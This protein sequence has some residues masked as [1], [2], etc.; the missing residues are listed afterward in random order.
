MFEFITMK[1]PHLSLGF[2]NRIR[3][4]YQKHITSKFDFVADYCKSNQVRNV[5]FTGDV[6]DSSTE[7]KWS[8]KKYR[9]NKRF[10]ETFIDKSDTMLYSNV[11]NHDMFHGFENS[12]DTIF[13]EMVHDGIINNITEV[14]IRISDENNYVKV[15]GIDYSNE[16]NIVL[17]AIRLFDEET[18]PGTN[19]FKIAILHS[20]VTPNE[21][22]YVTD[23]T[24]ATLVKDFPDIDMFI[25]GHYHVGYDTIVM[26]RE[27]GK[28]CHLIN[29][30]NFTRVVRDYETELDEHTPEFEHVLITYD[31]IL[32][33]FIVSTKTVQVPM[34]PYNDAFVAKAID[35]LKKSKAEIF[36]F[37]DNFDIADIKNATSTDDDMITKIKEKNDYTDAAYIKAVEYLND[38][39]K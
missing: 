21:V 28:D 22:D 25:F 10:L 15:Q 5:L 23:F 1:D 7:D 35:L 14:P 13:G 12:N 20:N 8:F 39:K 3:T 18:Y 38:A 36:N 29:N 37:F 11:G 2:Q 16:S 24:Y 27:G 30:W 33:T 17:D 26:Q 6:F 19:M 34:V 4:D 9:K 32:G 31:K